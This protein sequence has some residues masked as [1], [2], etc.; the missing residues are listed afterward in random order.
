MASGREGLNIY[1]PG[2]RKDREMCYMI[3]LPGALAKVFGISK[4]RKEI[5][6][7]VLRSSLSLID[8]LLETQGVGRILSIDPPLRILPNESE[9]DILLATEEATAA[10][11]SRRARSAPL[12][13]HNSPRSVST[14]LGLENSELSSSSQHEEMRRPST[15]ISE[16]QGTPSSSDLGE[17]TPRL[18]PDPVLRSVR[19]QS[20]EIFQQE[21][22]RSSNAYQE[23][24][25][26]VIQIAGRTTLPHRNASR[27]V[28]SGQVHPGF[29]HAAAFG[30]RNQNQLAHDTKIGVAGELFVCDFKPPGFNEIN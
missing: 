2:N 26:Q 14:I 30:M 8:D 10:S 27:Q 11:V 3:S 12:I 21:N 5:I 23:L 20:P 1:V 15:A 24:L 28:G 7:Y 19:S 4:S 25:N 17:P 16:N 18:S 13:S 29:N 22:L 6:G 9:E